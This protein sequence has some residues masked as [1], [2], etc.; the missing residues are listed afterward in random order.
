MCAG[1]GDR[2]ERRPTVVLQR[3]RHMA[4]IEIVDAVSQLQATVE[5]AHDFEQ[6]A[7][8]VGRIGARMLA[9]AV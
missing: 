6:M 3:D 4:D 1:D 7:L 2:I 8:V 5:G 9:H